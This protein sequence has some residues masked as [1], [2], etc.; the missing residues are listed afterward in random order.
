MFLSASSS[1][2]NGKFIS[3]SWY[4]IYSC[5]SGHAGTSRGWEGNPHLSLLRQP[6]HETPS[7]STGPRKVLG[8]LGIVTESVLSQLPNTASDDVLH[9][10]FN[11]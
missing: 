5:E 2:L 1:P 6:L 9:G 10:I 8:I 11:A 3:V 7:L 4:G